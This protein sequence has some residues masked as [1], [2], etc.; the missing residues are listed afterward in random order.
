M[1]HPTHFYCLTIG[2]SI[3]LGLTILVY[4]VI[5]TCNSDT[6]T[7]V[8]GV[9]HDVD[10]SML[11]V[12]YRHRC[13]HMRV[14]C[15]LHVLG[16]SVI[17]LSNLRIVLH[18]RATRRET[19]LMFGSRPTRPHVTRYDTRVAMC[20]LLLSVAFA[21][22]WFP[23]AVAFMYYMIQDQ[24]VPMAWVRNNTHTHTHTHRRRK[25]HNT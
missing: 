24:H 2:R 13:H 5:G 23:A 1:E 8:C 16:F 3:Y 6:W 21:V 20:M 15:H 11:F 4:V 22:C 10:M 9:W 18:V 19:A 17:F 14:V 7:C 12:S 25:P